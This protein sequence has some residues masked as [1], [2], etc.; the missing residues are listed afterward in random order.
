MLQIARPVDDDA[1]GRRGRLF[2][3]IV[4]EEALAVGGNVVIVPGARVAREASLE[5]DSWSADP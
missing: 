3:E 4:D 2:W 5:K 1:D